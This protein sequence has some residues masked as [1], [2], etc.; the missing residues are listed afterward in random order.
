MKLLKT[1]TVLI[2]FSAALSANPIAVDAG[3]Y[4]FCFAGVVGSPAV[5][6]CQNEAIGTAGNTITFTALNNVYLQV[7]D[8]FLKGDRFNVWVDGMLSFATSDVAIQYG[9][10][11]NPDA[12]FADPTYS[13]G[14]VLLAPGYY[15]VDIFALQTPYPTGGGAYMRVVTASVPDGGMTLMLLCGALLGLETL[16]RRFRN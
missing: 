2:V 6:G 9:S 14:Q 15:E 10:T 5:E 1:V 12:A 7:T 11:T 3:W 8:A 13:S 16:R 4:G